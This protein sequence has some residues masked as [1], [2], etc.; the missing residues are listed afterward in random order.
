MTESINQSIEFAPTV[1]K[2]LVA[3]DTTPRGMNHHEWMNILVMIYSILAIRCSSTFNVRT[4]LSHNTIHQCF[5]IVKK[6]P[7][8]THRLMCTCTCVVYSSG[9]Y[10]RKSI[11]C[12]RRPPLLAT[13][14]IQKYLAGPDSISDGGKNAFLVVEWKQLHIR[15]KNHNKLS[16]CQKWKHHPLILLASWSELEKESIILV[17]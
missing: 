8:T 1:S 3:H 10:N 2:L 12:C 15:K 5:C 6:W 9:M 14:P 11:Q 7:H 4:S 17:F 16:F 13:S